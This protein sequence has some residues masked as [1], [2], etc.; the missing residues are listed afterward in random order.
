[1][2][3]HDDG[4]DAT[5]IERY[6]ARVSLPPD[7]VPGSYQ[8][9]VSRDGQ[10][11][12]PVAGQTLDVVAD[13]PSNPP[14]VNIASYPGCHANDGA[15]RSY[16]AFSAAF[17]A[18]SGTGGVVV[19]PAGE[20]ALTDSVGVDPLHGLVVPLGVSLRGAGL[21]QHSHRP[22][23]TWLPKAVFTLV[24]AQ[25]GVRHLLRRSVP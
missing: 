20:W 19:V 8:V 1:M 23:H 7:L 2:P 9:R 16:R 5:A 22:R 25:H 6:V 4:L 17:A 14:T 21:D 3:A 18:L 15:R 10:N 13:P 12:V 11:W 24:G